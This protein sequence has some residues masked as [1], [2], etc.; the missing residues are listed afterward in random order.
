MNGGV[1]GGFPPSSAGGAGARLGR[2]SRRRGT[3]E[4]G[5]GRG[6]EGERERGRPRERERKTP[7]KEGDT[8]LQL[9][10]RALLG[11]I[12]LG[13]A[14]PLGVEFFAQPKMYHST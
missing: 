14:P 5:R 7:F 4:K 1:R 3:G 8:S 2:K 9:P 10:F 13:V 6:R 12:T 11:S